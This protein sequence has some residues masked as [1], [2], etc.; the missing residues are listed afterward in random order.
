VSRKSL[1]VAYLL[2]FPLGAFG[3]HRVYL[4][5]HGWAIIYFF[6]GGLFSIGW[7]VD[8]FTLPAQVDRANRR[9]SEL[10]RIAPAQLVG[11][12]KGYRRLS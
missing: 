2:W 3:L 4:G 5:T 10:A 8:A 11:T 9:N 6:T 7:F 1:L 12:G